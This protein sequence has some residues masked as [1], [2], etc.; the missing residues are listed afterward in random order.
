MTSLRPAAVIDSR[1]TVSNDEQPKPRSQDVVLVHGVT[2]DG[3][4]LRVLRAR[5]GGLEQGAC[6]PLEEGKPIHGEVVQLRP[7]KECPVLCDVDVKVAAPARAPAAADRHGPP[8]V[9]T[10]AYRDNWDAIWARPAADEDAL[11]N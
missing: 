3:K 5:D 6:R 8:Q 4:G 11:P 7:R 2:D 9:A 1:Y 10:A